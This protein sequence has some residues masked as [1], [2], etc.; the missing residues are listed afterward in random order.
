M[1]GRIANRQLFFMLPFLLMIP[2]GLAF[3]EHASRATDYPLI[4]ASRERL[5]TQPSAQQTPLKTSDAHLHRPYVW[6]FTPQTM[7]LSSTDLFSLVPSRYQLHVEFTPSSYLDEGKPRLN[8]YPSF[9]LTSQSSL[10]FSFNRFRPRFNI[11]RAGLQTSLHFRGNG[12]KLNFR[13][14]AISTQLEFDVKITNNE[15]RFD[16]TY[17]Y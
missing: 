13:P 17:R 4:L 11:E 12:V 16:L 2:P 7:S 5:I 15:S 14:T 9:Q 3:E 6:S 10:G 1:D 8:A